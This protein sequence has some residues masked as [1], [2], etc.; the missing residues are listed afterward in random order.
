LDARRAVYLVRVHKKVLVLGAS[1]SGLSKLGE[2]EGDAVEWET[3]QA[4]QPAF[5]EVLERAL[6]KRK[7]DTDDHPA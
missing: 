1:E 5:R 7:T 6:N 3:G 2:L 4:A